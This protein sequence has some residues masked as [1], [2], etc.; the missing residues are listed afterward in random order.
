MIKIYKV[1]ED[2]IVSMDGQLQLVDIVNKENENCIT[3]AE[4]EC[5]TSEIVYFGEQE[6]GIENDFIKD[7]FF[8][9]DIFEYKYSYWECQLKENNPTKEQIVNYI[10][11]KN[12]ELPD[13][14]IEDMI[15]FTAFHDGISLRWLNSNKAKE[16]LEKVDVEYLKK[17]IKKL[18]I[19]MND[20]GISFEEWE[21]AD[22]DMLN[23][24][25]GFVKSAADNNGALI[26]A[27][28]YLKINGGE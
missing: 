9:A 24:L 4:G 23:K 25:M 18:E 8:G 28:Y 19:E 10:K 27:N 21:Q 1:S 5:A 22:E 16:L 3:L 2:N 11:N 7:L 20:M 14:Y 17:E 6:C 26:Y 15:K 12:A 13:E